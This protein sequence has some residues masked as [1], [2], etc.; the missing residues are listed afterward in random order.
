MKVLQVLDGQL[1]QESRCY[2]AGGTAIVLA[3]NEYRESVDV[4][5]LCDVDGYRMLRSAITMPTLGKLVTGPV[6]YARDVR[7]D[8]DKISTFLEVDGIPTKVEFVIENRIRISGAFDATLGV[9]VL[10]RSDLYAEKL[11]ANADRGLDR[12]VMSRDLIDLAMMIRAW[13]P[14]PEEAWH[15]AV[16][17]YGNTVAKAYEQSLA[18]LED[19]AY[20]KKC[21][22]TMSMAPDL[23]EE[24]MDAL[25]TP[26]PGGSRSTVSVSP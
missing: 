16:N 17:I 25:R 22:D 10:S 14:I 6:K 3:L 2:F 26:H 1:L 13:G 19:R 5:F 18:L 24:I 15:K 8:R 20:F 9:P 12:S 21:L 11:L 4:D 23:G 7:A